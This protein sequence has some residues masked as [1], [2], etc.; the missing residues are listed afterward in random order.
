MPKYQ[1]LDQKG[2]KFEREK[3]YRSIA[4][5]SKDHTLSKVLNFWEHA[6]DDVSKAVIVLY[7]FVR[8]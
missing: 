5:V 8:T 4:V 2:T 1:R 7:F 3:I 6:R